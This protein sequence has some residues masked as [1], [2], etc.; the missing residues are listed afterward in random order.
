MPLTAQQKSEI[1]AKYRR[2][3]DDVGS[4]EVQVAL[5]TARIEQCMRHFE[6]H[7]RDRHSRHGLMRMVQARRSLLRHLQSR[8]RARYTSLIESLGLRR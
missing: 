6:T 8:E 4:P 2:G 3:P 1:I 5:L 7:A